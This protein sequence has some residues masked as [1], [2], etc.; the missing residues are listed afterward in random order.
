MCRMTS[1][2]FRGCFLGPTVSLGAAELAGGCLH[3]VGVGRLSSPF[4]GMFFLFQIWQELSRSPMR[5]PASLPQNASSLSSLTTAGTAESSA[6]R[7]RLPPGP[8]L[9]PFGGFHHPELQPEMQRWPFLLPLVEPPARPQLSPLPTPLA[10]PTP[11]SPC[12]TQPNK[13]AQ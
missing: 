5:T 1:R 3:R 8:P 11:P 13:E 7:H 6:W 10:V 4:W 12:T 2:T 9:T